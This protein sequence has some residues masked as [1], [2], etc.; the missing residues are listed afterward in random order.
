MEDLER[1]TST[2]TPLDLEDFRIAIQAMKG[3]GA[4]EVYLFA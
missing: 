1:I 4:E 2:F 3:L